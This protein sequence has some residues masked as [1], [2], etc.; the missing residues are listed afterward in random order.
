MEA[1]RLS[2]S[3]QRKNSLFVSLSYT[4][5]VV[6]TRFR[7][8]VFYKLA[9]AASVENPDM[10]GILES[11]DYHSSVDWVRPGLPKNL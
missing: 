9:D 7:L 10:T 1:S 8:L 2:I 4:C 3:A 6:L 5:S 11:R